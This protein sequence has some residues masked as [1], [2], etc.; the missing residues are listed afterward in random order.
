LVAALRRT[1]VAL[2]QTQHDSFRHWLGRTLE[3]C[4]LQIEGTRLTVTG[5]A[6]TAAYT[7][8]QW[9]AMRDVLTRELGRVGEL[10]VVIVPY[11]APQISAPHEE[12]GQYACRGS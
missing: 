2:R 9:G 11:T 1:Y 7:S 8:T 10:H 12:G 4:T 5:S 3:R 6:W